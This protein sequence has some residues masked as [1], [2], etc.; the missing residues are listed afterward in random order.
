M[1]IV[2]RPSNKLYGWLR[3]KHSIS[4]SSRQTGSGNTQYGSRWIHNIDLQQ[5]KKIKKSEPLPE[6]WIE[7]RKVKFEL[8]FYSCKGCG[9]RFRRSGLEVYC[10]E[11]CKRQDKSESNKIIDQHLDEMLEYYQTVWSID[12]TLKHF[13]VKGNRA[14]NNY[15]SRI[16]KS[17]N[18][19]VRRRRNS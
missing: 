6:G 14:G 10:S 8:M 19:Y 7:G 12:K 5:N 2:N 9:A 16:L 1:M 3:R 4:Q 18:I 13:G 17:K 11:V 15:F